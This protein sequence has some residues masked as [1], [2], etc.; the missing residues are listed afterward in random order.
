M[1]AVR[2]F[3]TARRERAAA[4]HTCRSCP[5]T[6]GSARHPA[7]PPP[8]RTE[9]AVWPLSYIAMW[10]C[11]GPPPAQV[12]WARFELHSATPDRRPHAAPPLSGSPRPLL[13]TLALCVTPALCSLLCCALTPAVLRSFIYAVAIMQYLVGTQ[14]VG[15]AFPSP[16]RSASVQLGAALRALWRLLR[17]E[18]ARSWAGRSPCVVQRCTLYSI[19]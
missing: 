18:H 6:A 13:C 2:W 10:T 3:L 19:K 16:P 4:S 11:R 7:P 12:C 1:P 14:L 17:Q 8:M 5:T 9:L 15:R